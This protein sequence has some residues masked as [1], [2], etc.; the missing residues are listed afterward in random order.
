MRTLLEN[1]IQQISG[2][3]SIDFVIPLYSDPYP[4]YV[5]YDPYLVDYYYDPVVY[6]DPIYYYDAPI[7]CDYYGC[8][9]G[10]YIY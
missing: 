9:D 4:T 10:Y 7:Y 2:G 6:Y 1:E 3:L 8:T 5:T